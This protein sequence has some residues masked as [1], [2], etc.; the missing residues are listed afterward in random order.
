MFW[1]AR[2]AI[3]TKYYHKFLNIYYSINRNLIVFDYKL[4]S[5]PYDLPENRLQNFK[6]APNQLNEIIKDS[7]IH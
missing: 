3:L 1:M 2:S 5:Q 6:I 4:F 7:S